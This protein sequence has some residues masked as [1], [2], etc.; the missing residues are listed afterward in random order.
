M[1]LGNK[2]DLRLDESANVVKTGKGISI[3]KKIKAV[4]YYECSALN[5]SG[6]D[7]PFNCAIKSLVKE[8]KKFRCNILWDFIENL[9]KFFDRFSSI[10]KYLNIK[11]LYVPSN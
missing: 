5:N 9:C 2:S 3:S 4:G 7:S 10:F 1:I 8:E 11:Y 6:V